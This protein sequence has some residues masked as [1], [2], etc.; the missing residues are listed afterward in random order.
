MN[1]VAERLLYTRFASFYNALLP[2][3][4]PGVIA[5]ARQCFDRYGKGDVI[6]ILDLGCGTGSYTIALAKWVMA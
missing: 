4:D 2:R 3:F 1:V 6:G 5:F